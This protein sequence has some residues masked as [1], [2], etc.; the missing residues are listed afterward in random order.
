MWSSHSIE[1]FVI[2]CHT[3]GSIRIYLLPT[4]LIQGLIGQFCS[5]VSFTCDSI[6]LTLV[7]TGPTFHNSASAALPLSLYSSFLP[8]SSPDSPISTS[9]VKALNSCT[10]AQVSSIKSMPSRDQNS[11]PMGKR[12][13]HQYLTRVSPHV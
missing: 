3:T 5:I 10:C 9:D 13:L 12:Q 1:G 2:R 8:L 4:V 11:R 7:R 6:L